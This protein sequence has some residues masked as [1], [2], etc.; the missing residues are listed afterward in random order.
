MVSCFCSDEEV[1]AISLEVVEIPPPLSQG[2]GGV[3]TTSQG[4]RS[5]MKKRV[6]ASHQG[7]STH[8]LWR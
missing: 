6:A 2:G 4:E 7:V 3:S 1:V 8:V 5:E